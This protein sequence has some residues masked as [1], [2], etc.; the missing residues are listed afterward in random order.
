MT[1]VEAAKLLRAKGFGILHQ[2]S[3]GTLLSVLECHIER[4]DMESDEETA[5]YQD[6]EARLEGELRG[7]VDARLYA[8]PTPNAEAVRP[9]VGG[10][11]PAQGSTA[12]TTKNGD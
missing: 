6:L 4:T 2:D 9:A 8:K 11:E 5:L 3:L 7:I 1:T 10:S 12:L